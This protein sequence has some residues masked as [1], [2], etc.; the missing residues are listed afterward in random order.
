M[1][2]GRKLSDAR[3]RRGVS[4]SEVASATRMKVQIVNSL[5]EED[6]S[7]IAAPI[8]GK[9]FIKL[10]A[11]YVGLDP[12]PLIDE[13]MNEFVNPAPPP[14]AATIDE[15]VREVSSEEIT[16]SH[17]QETAPEEQA[18]GKL[19]P[20]EPVEEEPDLFSSSY[21]QRIQKTAPSAGNRPPKKTGFDFN[22]LKQVSKEAL[23]RAKLECSKGI[24][25][26]VEATTR[27]TRYLRSRQWRLPKPSIPQ[28]PGKKIAVGA[29][30]LLVVI[31]VIS[32]LHSCFSRTEKPKPAPETEVQRELR[33]AFDPPEPF[34]DR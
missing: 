13:Y 29:G 30:I 5:E 15:A 32:S 27:F 31:L 20:A 26:L 33:P 3:K 9:G 8:Y 34:V 23:T 12:Q 7:K 22:K 6:F 17:T 2:L 11:E 21:K 24:Q 25:V 18:E 28:T 19:E 14:T 16:P 10:Y 4:Q 1:A